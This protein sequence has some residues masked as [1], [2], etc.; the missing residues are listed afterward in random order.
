MYKSEDMKTE[1]GLLEGK[2]C[3]GVSLSP[4][5]YHLLSLKS[6]SENYSPFESLFRC[7][8]TLVFN[9]NIFITN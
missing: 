8:L 5:T 2:G 7:I 3:G 1:E 4:P 9:C 6:N